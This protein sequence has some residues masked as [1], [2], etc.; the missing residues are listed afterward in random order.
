MI[1]LKKDESADKYVNLQ[2]KEEVLKR[3]QEILKLHTEIALLKV[4]F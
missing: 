3:D 4:L 2:Y 1:L